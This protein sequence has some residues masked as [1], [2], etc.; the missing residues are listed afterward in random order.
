[1]AR[2]CIDQIL[3]F[4]SR[5]HGFLMLILQWY[6]YCWWLL[7]CLTVV[8]H[9]EGV[10]D[11]HVE[12]NSLGTLSIL[13]IR[14]RLGAALRDASKFNTLTALAFPPSPARLSGQDLRPV[15][16]SYAI[17]SFWCLSTIKWCCTNP[18][19]SPFTQ[20]PC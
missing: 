11:I 2:H 16:S 20:R 8:S 19:S 12:S 13:F 7:H 9:G 1:M 10:M 6:L 14:R 18:L 5:L 3:D 17:S 15:A 4:S